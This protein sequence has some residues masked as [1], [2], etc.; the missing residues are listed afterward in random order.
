MPPDRVRPVHGPWCGD[1]P[2]ATRRPGS[3]V[4][5]GLPGGKQGRRSLGN[6]VRNTAAPAFRSA[7]YTCRTAGF[8]PASRHRST[9]SYPRQVGYALLWT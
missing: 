1:E 6:S 9:V 5:T 2:H 7:A 8:H 4:T 3:L